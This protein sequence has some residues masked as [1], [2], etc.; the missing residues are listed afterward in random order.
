MILVIQKI[1]QQAGNSEACN[2]LGGSGID[3][4]HQE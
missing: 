1:Q 2:G 4:H 3:V